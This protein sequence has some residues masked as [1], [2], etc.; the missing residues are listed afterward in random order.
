MIQGVRSA[1][2]VTAYSP[3]M[4]CL[5]WKEAYCPMWARKFV[6]NTAGQLQEAL[7]KDLEL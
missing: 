2:Q 5:N 7:V 1:M 4:L 3:V 6:A